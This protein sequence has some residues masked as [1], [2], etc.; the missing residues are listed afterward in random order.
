M[1]K[2]FKCVAWIGGEERRGARCQAGQQIDLIVFERESFEAAGKFDAPV[3]AAQHG[4]YRFDMLTRACQQIIVEDV[5]ALD[6]RQKMRRRPFLPDTAKPTPARAT[7]R[8]DGVTRLDVAAGDE[9]QAV[10]AVCHATDLYRGD[11]VPLLG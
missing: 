5:P 10:I 1:L 11:R 6:D 3:L 4:E 8:S 7:A 2:R 9:F